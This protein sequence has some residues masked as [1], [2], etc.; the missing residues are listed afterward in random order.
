MTALLG[1]RNV[2]DLE[3]LFIYLCLHSGG[4]LAHNACARALE[5]ATST[6]AYHLAL[7]EQANLIYRLPPAALGGKKVL[8]ARNKYYLV[9][10]AL[11]NAILL[12]GEVIFTNPDEM[13]LIVEIT[14]LRHL[15]AYYDRDIPEVVY[16]REFTSGKEVASSFA[17]RPISF[18]LRSSTRKSQVWISRMD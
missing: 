2:N 3:K 17:A 8:K 4:I 14:V 11:R 18:P 1:V 15:Y 6:V 5:T 7:L 10:A 9:D 13:G 12:K 16:W